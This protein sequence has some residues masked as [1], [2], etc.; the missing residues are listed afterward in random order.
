[1]R[2]GVQDLPGL[3]VWMKPPLEPWTGPKIYV[4]TCAL[5]G[6]AAPRKSQGYLL[7]VSANGLTVGETLV[8]GQDTPSG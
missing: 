3:V 6:L 5:K 4:N 8:V 7:T 2:A 1:M